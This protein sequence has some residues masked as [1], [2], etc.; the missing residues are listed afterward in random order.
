[1][2]EETKELIVNDRRHHVPADIG[3]SNGGG[4]LMETLASAVQ[5][6]LPVETL[7][8]LMDFQER[9]AAFEA[10][11]AFDAAMAAA[12]SEIPV[13]LKNREVDFTSA[14]GRTYYKHED[15]AGIA[16]IVDPI[17]AQHGLSYR[18][19][20]VTDKDGVTVTCIVSHRDGHSEKNTLNAGSDNSGNKN[21]IQA[22]GST[23]T[24]LQRYT[25]KA[26]LGLAAS[27]DD[28]A[29][30]SEQQG[31]DPQEEAAPLLEMI[32]TAQS[33]SVPSFK[34]RLQEEAKKRGLSEAA[35]KIVKAKFVEALNEESANG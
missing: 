5:R 15:L 6:G 9:H 7:N 13:I 19:N 10:R 27:N 29:A 23:I 3:Q 18:F 20:T 16:K 28:D 21:S 33:V 12:K 24:Y 31:Q 8:A 26:A 4:S 22:I 11:K 2:S 25:L 34:P 14:K 30:S 35:F 32:E 17:L 1:M